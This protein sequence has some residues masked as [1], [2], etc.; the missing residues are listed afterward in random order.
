MST[1]KIIITQS[2]L[3]SF[4]GSEIVTLELADHLQR[5]GMEVVVFTWYLADPIK[6]EFKKKQIKVTDNSNDPIL[7]NP[8]YVWV[9]HQVIPDCILDN[10]ARQTKQPKFIFLH[11]SAH[12]EFPIE[13]NYI[14]DLERRLSSKS[15]FV[16][17][18]TVDFAK[19]NYL[20]FDKLKNI[21]VFPNPAPD[22]FLLPCQPK[23]KLQK[24]LIVSNHPAPEMEKAC[25]ILV[26]NGIK[27][28]LIGKDGVAKLVDRKTLEH[29][30][31]V[32]TIGKTV[33][34]CLCMG[35]PVYVYDKFG[36]PGYLTET[37]LEQAAYANFSGRGFSKKSPQ[38]IA[39]EITRLYDDALAFQTEH[40]EIFIERYSLKNN[41]D[42]ILKDLPK[43][44]IEPF[45][46]QYLNYVHSIE[47]IAWGKIAN[48]NALAITQK[49]LI[50][51]KEKLAEQIERCQELENVRII[52]LARKL[53][54][55]KS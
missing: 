4:A 10:L 6:K 36:G 14:Y 30:D 31:L 44:T 32:V 29:Q 55:K 54:R 3:R 47:T 19:A 25:Q 23:G 7:A 1:P 27:V 24:M 38:K 35:L 37:N 52:R 51:T 17:K 26:D 15:L 13:Q 41:L 22:E 42:K 50:E 20:D 11:M 9:H 40:R 5:N 18:E 8:D 16:A 28:E 49:E 43:V 39:D 45:S 2:A 12:K 21:E 53:R 34:Y 33:Q 46:T 48:E